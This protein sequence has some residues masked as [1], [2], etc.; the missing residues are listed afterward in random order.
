MKKPYIC[1]WWSDEKDCEMKQGFSTYAEAVE[2][3]FKKSKKINRRV[4]IILRNKK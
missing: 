3:Q 2:F 1:T 4:N